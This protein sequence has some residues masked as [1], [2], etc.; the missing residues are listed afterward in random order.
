MKPRLTYRD[1]MT[2]RHV[3]RHHFLSLGEAAQLMGF[4]AGQ[5]M[6]E[7]TLTHMRAVLSTT[8]AIRKAQLR[9]RASTRHSQ[10]SQPS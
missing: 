4:T 6:P 3:A 2:L 10:Q 9:A 7:I 8:D 1:F 5:R